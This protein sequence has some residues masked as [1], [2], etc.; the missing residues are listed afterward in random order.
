MNTTLLTF[1]KY[2]YLKLLYMSSLTEYIMLSI[3]WTAW[4]NYYYIIILWRNW[5]A[6][7]PK[8]IHYLEMVESNFSLHYNC[9]IKKTGSFPGTFY[10]F[11]TSEI[12]QENMSYNQTKMLSVTDSATCVTL[13]GKS[14]MK[15]RIMPML[16]GV[17]YISQ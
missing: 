5:V 7:S 3:F 9:H 2:W 17:I 4:V 8:V 15:K 12:S 13:C 10:L 14:F 6:L 1:R 11:R 16:F